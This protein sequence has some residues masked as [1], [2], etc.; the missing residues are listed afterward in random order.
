MRDAHVTQ[1]TPYRVAH[2]EKHVVHLIYKTR[3]FEKATDVKLI[4]NH[5]E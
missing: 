4:D 3:G 1:I 2:H 5:I